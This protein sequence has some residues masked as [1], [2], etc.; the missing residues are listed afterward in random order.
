VSD[1]VHGK[2]W[3][4]KDINSCAITIDDPVY[5]PNKEKMIFS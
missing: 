3:N 5:E 4:G 1:G 2:A